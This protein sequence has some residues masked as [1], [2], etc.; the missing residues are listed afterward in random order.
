LLRGSEIGSQKKVVAPGDVLLSRIIPHIRR[1]WVVRENSDGRRQI[2]STE[3][4][5]FS[6]EEVVPGFLRQLL[7][8]DFFHVSFMQTI[9][10]VGG[11][12]SRANPAAVGEIK[13]PLPPLEVQKEIVAEIEGYQKV[14][15]GARAVLDHY[16]PHI[17]IHPDWPM[18]ELGEVCDVRDG[19]H[20]SPKYVLDGYPLIT[21]KNLKDGFVDFTEVNLISRED[22]DAINKRSK[23]DAGDLL[24]PMIGTIGNPVIA[25]SSREYA[26]KNVALIKFPKGCQVD[27]RFLKDI[28]DSAEM[29]SRFDRESSGS[30]QRFI[31][32]GFIRKLQ[33]PRP[34][35]TTQQAIVAEIE[36]DQ[37]LVA[38]NRELISRFEKKIQATLARVWGEEEIAAPEA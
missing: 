27:N 18:A 29:Q 13:I 6:S 21:S 17:P 33:I 14:I 19:T 7:V 23:V 24:M 26:V 22:L 20:D 8:S 5:V 3:W 34:P 28:L 4:I 30:T 15:N 11:S 2:A 32:L 12:L 25:D 1:A 10:G 16:R 36:A 38:A 37:A 31:P 9:T 35:L